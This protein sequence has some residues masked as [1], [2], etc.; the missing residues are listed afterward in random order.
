MNEVEY[1][2]L[3][4]SRDYASDYVCVELE[5]RGRSYLRLDRDLL[6]SAKVALDVDNCI[7]AATVNGQQKRCS[8]SAL[9]AVYYRAPTYLRETFARAT[10]PDTQLE[11]SQWMAFYRNL[12]CFQ[13]ARW[14][15]NPNSTFCAEN[16]V[17]QL[18]TAKEVGFLIPATAVTN[19]WSSI[20]AC[21]RV[22]I[23]ALDTVVLQLDEHNEGFAYTQVVDPGSH[24]EDSINT[25][26]VISQEYLREK[27][28]LRVT[29][30]GSR[31][32]A[33]QILRDGKGVDGDWRIHK[34]NVTFQP[35]Q[36]PEP[37]AK[38]CIALSQKLGLLFSGIDL[39][40]VNDDYYFI[41]VNPT[42]EWAWLIDAAKLRIDHAICDCL[43]C[44]L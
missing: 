43:E 5:R 15:N 39:A 34:N 7:L 4:D 44:S 30:V 22:V 16:K 3:S 12:A 17:V 21:D 6:G 38:R 24:G 10:T 40:V 23:K 41:E 31:L 26:P 18:R 27:I 36:L 1:L 8:P 14:M 32:F 13:N 28:D 2:I 35:T 11:N 37:V 42:G 29:V 20:P 19:T 25:A 33:V 9:K